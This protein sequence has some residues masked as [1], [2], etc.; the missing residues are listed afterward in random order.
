MHEREPLDRTDTTTE[1]DRPQLADVDESAEQTIE[2]REEELVVHREMQDVGEVRVRRVVEE[3]PARM[4]V[5]ARSEEVEVEHV[6]IGETVSE[7]REPWDEDGVLVVPVYEER[8]V[9]TKRLILREQLRIRRVDGTRRELIE[10]TV[11]RERIVVEDPQDTGL[12]HERY[13]SEERAAE[14]EPEERGG[15]VSEFVR[16]AFQ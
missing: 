12:V 5:D 11:R 9:V 7:R 8:L 3:Q 15:I 4:E 6:A 16:K 14:E 10:D 1:L 13:A 2:L